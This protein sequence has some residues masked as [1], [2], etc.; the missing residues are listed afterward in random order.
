MLLTAFR[1]F[2]QGSL[3]HARFAAGK[4]DVAVGHYEQALRLCREQNDDEGVRVYL[5]TLFESH[6]YLG[7][8]DVAADY[9]RELEGAW[10]WAG[11]L[12]M[13]RR[14]ARLSQ[15]VRDGEPLLRMVAHCDGNVMELDEV[16]MK[17]SMK[18]EMHFWRN[19]PSLPGA[20]KR[21]ERGKE[22]AAKQQYDE[23][24]DLFRE[25]AKVDP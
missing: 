8:T 9:A 1:R 20:S 14:Y 11:K 18:M 22:L 15:M 19:R 16:E 13:A 3:G 24:L 5:A 4:V 17:P 12:A 25:A 2:S 7:K 6:R 23:A 21:V 10:E